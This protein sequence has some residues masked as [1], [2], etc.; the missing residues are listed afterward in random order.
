MKHK[1]LFTSESVG[2]GHPDKICD[3]ISDAILDE[4]LKQDPHARVAIE[5]MATG[6][7]YVIGG[8]V[9]STVQV[10]YLKVAE[11]VVKQVGLNWDTQA[12]LENSKNCL[13]IAINVVKEQ[14]PDISQGVLQKDGE[15]GAGDQGI[16]FGYA[17]NETKEYMPLAI[18][19]AHKILCLAEELRAN[20]KFKWARSDMKSQVTVDYT[21]SKHPKID[22]VLVSIQHTEDF[23]EQE[24]KDFIKTEIIAKVLQEYGFGLPE[25]ILINPTGRFV[26]G[27]SEGDC[28]L[29]GRKIIV[30]TYGGAAR[31]GG[32]A[33][34]GK[35]ATKVDRS[36]A[37][38][39]RWIA[40]NI[41]ATGIV[42]KLELQISYAIGVAKPTSIAINT[43]GLVSSEV[44]EKILSAIDQFFDL[45]PAA[46]IRELDLRKPIYG[47]T[48]YFGHFGRDDLD[49]PWER[50]NKVSE[51]KAFFGL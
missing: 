1:I 30:D 22:T 13:P 15:I 46:I 35:D 27:G 51:L 7:M 28:G 37:Y 8:E 49:L 9:A 25:R 4:F 39:A 19:L 36:A 47:K 2:R 48:A 38:A 34:S 32:G 24:F 45:R 31:H 29:T 18:T 23:V 40:K 33:F 50:L 6:K 14:S 5:T 44:D 10:D 20:N 41:V 43:F 12:Q 16:M 26:I 17:T 11:K 3:Q 42:P 21:D